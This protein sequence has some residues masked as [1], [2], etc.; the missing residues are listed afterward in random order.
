MDG[1]PR[2]AVE[3]RRHAPDDG[4]VPAAARLRVLNAGSGLPT[5][6]VAR[7]LRD[8]GATVLQLTEPGHSPFTDEYP[9]APLWARDW[10]PVRRQDLPTILPSLDVL[11]VGGEDH[12][13]AAAPPRLT[14][15]EDRHPRLVVL[16]VGGYVPGWEQPTPATDLLVQARTGFVFEQFRDQPTQFAFAPTLYG[17]A[18]LGTLGG[19]AALLQRRRTGRGQRVR[20]SL[21]QGLAL[22]WPHL[23]LSAERPDEAFDA[24]PPRD[25]Q[26]LAFRCADGGFV[27]IVLGVPRALAKVYRVLGIPGPV[28][29]VDRGAANPARGPE[30]YFADR[31]LLAPYFAKM[32]RAELVEA[33][34]AVGI[35]AEPVLEPG[36]CFDDPQ[37]RAA[38][39]VTVDPAGYAWPSGAVTLTWCPGDAGPARPAPPVA[40]VAANSPVAAAD[41]DPPLA[42]I[43]VVDLGNWVAG[44]YA[45]KLLADLGADVI[46]V[47][48][49]AG[50]SNLTGLRNTLA[51]NRGKRAIVLDLKTTAGLDTMRRLVATADAVHHNF[52]LG[53]AERLGVDAATLRA[54]RPDLVYLHTTA[55]GRA[56]PRAGRSGFDMVMQA[57]GGHEARAGGAGN[58]P[59]WYRSPYLDYA[60]GALGA[61]GLLAGLYERAESGAGVDVHTSLLSAALFLRGEV[62]RRPDG[63]LA[64]RARLAAD[65][66]GFHPAEALYRAADGWVA[67]DARGERMS[68]ALAA[69]LGLDGLGARARWGAGARAVVAAAVATRPVDALLRLLADAGVWATRCADDAFAALLADDAA[70]QAA[71]VISVP[72]LRFGRVTG[73]FGPLVDVGERTGRQGTHRSAPLPGEHAHEVLAELGLAPDEPARPAG[74]GVRGSGEPP[75]VTTS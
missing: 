71:L 49:P 34:A 15:V 12:P 20:V 40:A 31:E 35:A 44:P 22:F 19:W 29:P 65:R 69:A 39:L 1:S 14:G 45:S 30:N 5:A 26:H 37:V 43:R 54:T 61:I 74:G 66:L 41:G 68:Q 56:G 7:L 16:E 4:R 72:D 59:L 9:A 21:Q 75:F 36:E 64:G 28:D 70:W 63:S 62:A 8:A 58:G 51:S 38:G 3:S 57:L 53:V 23:W 10:A 47:E 13:E 46:K 6:V 17:A 2:H 55:Y 33:F 48:P 42:G 67:I 11:L 24:V 18:L 50:L 27:Q 32:P 73:C 52:R 60:A 25:V